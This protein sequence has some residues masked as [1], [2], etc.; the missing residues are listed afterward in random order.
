[1]TG[2]RDLD[3]I[4]RLMRDFIR[5]L[6]GLLA[7]GLMM[8]GAVWGQG[9]AGPVVEVILVDGVMS[10][11]W[12]DDGVVAFRREGMVGDLEGGRPKFATATRGI[13]NPPAS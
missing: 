3:I 13:R 7:L 11:A 5:R 9:V 8:A 4:S 10:E 2:G 12:P 6:Y 1:M